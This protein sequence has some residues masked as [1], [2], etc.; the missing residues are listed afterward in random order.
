MSSFRRVKEIHMELMTTDYL[1]LCVRK[2]KN[3]ITIFDQAFMLNGLSKIEVIARESLRNARFELLE[4]LEA[5]KSEDI[6][7]KSEVFEAEFQQKLEAFERQA[8]DRPDAPEKDDEEETREA[9]YWRKFD[10][11]GAI[12]I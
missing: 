1:E 12:I 5:R 4:E 9:V 7:D 3:T 6:D 10:E 2:L 8:E 11:T